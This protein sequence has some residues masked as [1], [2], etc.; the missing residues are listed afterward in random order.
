MSCAK[1]T[2]NYQHQPYIP[3]IRFITATGFIIF[4]RFP[5]AGGIA[6]VTQ[7]RYE[8]VNPCIR[9]VCNAELLPGRLPSPRADATG[10]GTANTPE[11]GVLVSMRKGDP[12]TA[13]KKPSQGLLVIS[14]SMPGNVEGQSWWCIYLGEKG[15]GAGDA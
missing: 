15:W 6:Y 7:Y 3:S 12:K 11:M 9:I 14:A 2:I 5:F 13:S 1:I 10:A 4:H 8:A